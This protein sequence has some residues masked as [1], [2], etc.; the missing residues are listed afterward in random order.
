MFGTLLEDEASADT[1]SSYSRLRS[2]SWR[3]TTRALAARAEGHE[4]DT[5]GGA[6]ADQGATPTRHRSG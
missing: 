4:P 6:D 5:R 3:A 2:A 1:L